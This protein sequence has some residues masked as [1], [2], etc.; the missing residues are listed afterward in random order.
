MAARPAV[1]TS[2]TLRAETFDLLRH[3]IAAHAA[4]VA[5]GCAAHGPFPRR[6]RRVLERLGRGF[7][8]GEDEQHGQ[9]S[10]AHA[11]DADDRLGVHCDFLSAPRICRGLRIAVY[12]AL[13]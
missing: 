8:A 9:R 13:V 4:A 10:H 2:A 6:L 1:H 3:P 7:T 11:Y 5:F 12:G